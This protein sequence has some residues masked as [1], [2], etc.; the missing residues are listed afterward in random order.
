[1]SHTALLLSKQADKER[2]GKMSGIMLL[3]VSLS[4]CLCPTDGAARSRKVIQRDALERGPVSLNDMFR[5]LEELMEDTQ[6]ILKETV[7]QVC[8]I[9]YSFI[10]RQ[11][12]S[13]Y[14]SGE[15]YREL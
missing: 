14:F 8:V 7:D 4:L 11:S 5:E 15:T 9:F 1:M 10:Q 13:L 3:L 6:H 2:E 12:C